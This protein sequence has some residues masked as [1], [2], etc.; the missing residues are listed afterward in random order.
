MA[1][2]QVQAP[3]ILSLGP[4]VPPTNQRG[5]NLL[6]FKIEVDGRPAIVAGVEDWSL[7]SFHVTAGRS[8]GG[9]ATGDS[10]DYHI[11]G[12]STPN[13]EHI[14]HHLRWPGNALTTGSRV[15]LTVIETDTPDAPA[16]RY[17]AD[18]EVQESPYTKE[19]WR[20]MRR[21]D[22]LQLKKEFE[23]DAGA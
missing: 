20:E 17:R 16:K 23:G 7:L 10:V 14:S 21:K 22:Y 1:D 2:C 6:A 4:H 19:E 13:A 15:T 8:R 5:S 3:N 18:H 11:G 12:L 9:D